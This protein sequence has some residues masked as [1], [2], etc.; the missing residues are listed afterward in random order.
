MC[1]C[2]CIHI[3]I[4]HVIHMVEQRDLCTGDPQLLM[5]EACMCLNRYNAKQ[6]LL[7]SAPEGQ[8]SMIKA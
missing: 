5:D 3:C 1:V 7:T 8:R 4:I 2:M 6:R